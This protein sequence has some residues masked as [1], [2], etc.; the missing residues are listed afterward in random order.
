MA[1]KR[2]N[3]PFTVRFVSAERGVKAE[4]PVKGRIAF[5]SNRG[6]QPKAGECWRVK[7]AGE[8]P[9]KTV[10]FLSCI[11]RIEEKVSDDDSVPRRHLVAVKV[12]LA[13][14]IKVS[15]KISF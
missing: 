7:I 2:S 11:E 9:R 10:F 1:I 14:P 3:L 8:N 4:A 13:V 15:A 5:P 12:P 6:P